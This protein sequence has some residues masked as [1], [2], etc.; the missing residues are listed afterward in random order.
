MAKTSNKQ[1]APDKTSSSS[2]D[3]FFDMY[4]HAPALLRV[5]ET[6]LLT[7]AESKAKDLARVS[8]LQLEV[9]PN[10]NLKSSTSDAS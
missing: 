1:N 10:P 7:S 8:G 3:I 9:I 2:A 5:G 6:Y 4:P